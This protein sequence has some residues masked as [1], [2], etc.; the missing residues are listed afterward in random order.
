VIYTLV[1]I[2]VLVVAAANAIIVNT[3]WG[4]RRSGFAPMATAT[5][6]KLR[7]PQLAASFIRRPWP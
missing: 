6:G 3:M 5:T 7:P 2:L 1:V 4:R